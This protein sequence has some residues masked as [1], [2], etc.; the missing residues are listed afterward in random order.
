MADD[1]PPVDPV[2]AAEQWDEGLAPQRTQLAWGRSGL[3][4][5]VAVAVLARRAW[6]AGGALEAVALVVVG[7][8][9]L[10]WL[11]GMQRSRDLHLP[12]APHGL[13]GG[14]AFVLVTVGTLLLAA[15][16]LSLGVTLHR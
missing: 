1:R 2:R 15:G 7:V 10:V 3:A 5:G 9:G 4:M 8:G 6:L 14:R 16:A 13:T 12:M 11:V